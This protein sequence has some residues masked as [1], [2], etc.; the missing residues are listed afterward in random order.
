[1]RYLVSA[2]HKLT[3]CWSTDGLYVV[4]LQFDTPRCQPVH[5]RRLDL[6]AMVTNVMETIIIR[7]NEDDVWLLLL[8]LDQ[9]EYARHKEKSKCSEE[10]C[11]IRCPWLS[12]GHSSQYSNLNNNTGQK[13]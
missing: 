5:I 11:H 9:M 2:T 1:M 8:A 3:P 4:I 6:R 13:K 10:S 7:Q 12:H